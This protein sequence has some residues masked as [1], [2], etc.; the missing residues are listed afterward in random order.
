MV[1]IDRR[2]IKSREAI[3]KAL[4]EL[5]AHQ[6]FD[7][8]TIQQIADQANVNR[9]TIYLHYLDKYDL[10]DKMME[11]Q[12]DELKKTSETACQ[13]EWIGA[14]EVFCEYFDTHYPFFSLMLA[15]SGSPYFRKH[16]LRFLLE[17]FENE[18]DMNQVQ[19]QDMDP[20]IILEFTSSAYV[21][22]IESWLKK[23]SRVHHSI[24][25]EQL[26]RLLERVM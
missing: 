1:K 4:I 17:A 25:A 8:I 12:I 19:N 2:I 21:G 23:E 13:L 16:F 20:S 18:L 10:L 6:D 9:A 26:G 3:K 5:M 24:L 11:E 7:H 22:V 15:N 14:T